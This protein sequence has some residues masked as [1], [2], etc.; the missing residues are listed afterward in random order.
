MTR[1][2]D[3]VIADL[4]S[5]YTEAASRKQVWRSRWIRFTGYVAFW[6]VI[7][8]H[9]TARA[10]PLTRE[11]A[12]ADDHALGRALAF[13]CIALGIVTMLLMVPALSSIIRHAGWPPPF[14]DA[15]TPNIIFVTATV[16]LMR[17]RVHI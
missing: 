7:G 5:E 8:L 1:L 17:K 16:V 15:W 11:W 2:I 6:K 14:I 4:Q 9:A 13:S 10:W 12:A 3:P